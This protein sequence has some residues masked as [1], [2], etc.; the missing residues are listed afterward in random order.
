MM[1]ENTTGTFRPKKG[2]LTSLLPGAFQSR[3]DVDFR[4]LSNPINTSLEIV[5]PTGIDPDQPSHNALLAPSHSCPVLLRTCYKAFKPPP[6]QTEISNMSD[7]FPK[8]HDMQQSISSM[9]PP[10]VGS[11]CYPLGSGSRPPVVGAVRGRLL[12]CWTSV[13]RPPFTVTFVNSCVLAVCC[14]FEDGTHRH[15]SNPP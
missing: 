7:I 2:A 10:P 12:L 14:V 1:H 9:E 15:D 13:F 4:P 3:Q 11:P 6:C 5:C 8:R